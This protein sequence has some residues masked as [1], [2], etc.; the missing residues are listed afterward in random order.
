MDM[1]DAPPPVSASAV[2]T[3][4]KGAEPPHGPHGA[5][6]ADTD[7]LPQATYPEKAAWIVMAAGL[8]FIL[9]FKLVPALIAG[10][11]VYGL[12]H[13]LTARLAG[14]R[15]S[16]SHAKIAVV[17]L[18]G[19]AIVGVAAALSVLLAAFFKGRMG[20]LPAL[21]DKMAAVLENVR[22][23][24]G[25]MAWIPAA[26]EMRGTV[27]TGLREHARELQQ[28]GGDAGRGLMHALVG[29]VIGALASFETR[30]P[31]APLP[32]ALAERLQRLARAFE[33]V[34]FAQG[35]ISMLNTLLAGLYLLIVLPLFGVEL[36][37]RKT[38]VV[39]TFVAGLIPIVGNLVANTAVVV[40]ALGTSLIVAA[41]SL[42]F[43]VIIHKLEYFVNARILGGEIHAAAWEILLAIFC[44]EAAFGIPGV[45]VAPIIYAYLKMELADR[46][47]I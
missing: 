38:L 19:L 10:L 26:E 9:H 3:A 5:P 16:H 21:L 46:K 36:P 39:V 45:I 25:G 17:S 14:S 34:V 31:E 41:A 32:M 44:F 24:L 13:V 2:A 30:R 42:V 11:C 33:K 35:K 12:I 22:D 15:L 23:R 20:D 6:A 18:L 47:L 40:I 29:I 8:L 7:S 27:V 1:P 4:V 37:L 28:V 43:L